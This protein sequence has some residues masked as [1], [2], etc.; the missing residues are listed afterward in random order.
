MQEVAL[1]NREQ[2]HLLLQLDRPPIIDLDQHG[3]ELVRDVDRVLLSQVINV[4]EQKL[5]EVNDQVDLHMLVVGL[6]LDA[7]DAHN[8]DDYFVQRLL[9]RCDLI[10]CIFVLL[11]SSRADSCR[12]CG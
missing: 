3:H 11:M 4:D 9:P 2:I 10:C 8:A 12:A 6:E 1:L 5:I 7:E